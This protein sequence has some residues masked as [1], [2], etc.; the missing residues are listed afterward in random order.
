MHF[1]R[2]TEPLLPLHLWI[3]R[4]VKSIGM[5]GIIV[6]ISLGIGVLG[7]HYLAPM[8]W[9]D[10]LLE[11]SMILGGEVMIETL[12]G[13]VKLKLQPTTQNGTKVRLK[14]KGFPV[15][16]QEGQ[17]GDLYVTYQAKLPAHLSDKE[18]EL[19]TQLSQLK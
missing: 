3:K 8:P 15:Y 9:L 17:F 6:V 7:Y 18:K 13:K 11:A 1:E 4:V 19:F 5:A 16:K 2:K 10:A 14:G 12:N